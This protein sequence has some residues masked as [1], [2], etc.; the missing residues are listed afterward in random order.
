MSSS[1][2]TNPRIVTK[3]DIEAI[4]LEPTFD[5][6]LI[7]AMADGFRISSLPST[8]G[9]GF[10]SAPIQT[11]GAYP[12]EPFSVIQSMDD[13]AIYSAQTCIK[14]GYM[15]DGKYYVIKVASGGNPFPNSG[16]MQI[17]SQVTGKLVAILMDDGILTELRTAAAG[18]LAAKLFAPKHIRYVGILG[19]GIQARYQLRFLK[20]VLDCRN[21]LVYGR[22]PAHVETFVTECN[23]DGWIVQTVESPDQLLQDCQLIITTTSAREPILGSTY[24]LDDM[25]FKR[26]H[27]PI[28]ITC[29][30]ADAPGK[31][32][33]YP[34]LVKACDLLVADSL[35]QTEQRGEFQHAIQQ[36]LIQIK[37]IMEIGQFIKDPKQP[38]DEKNT[39]ILDHTHKL[40]IFD[41]SGMAVQDYMIAS[42]VLDSLSHN[43]SR[44]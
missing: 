27:E 16:C 12:L 17:Y 41:S 14:S 36:G 19:T 34:N 33:L 24:T 3:S 30:G 23:Q 42:M 29:I 8:V 22:T 35:V 5:E 39:K 31:M 38:D 9:G 20:T 11:L 43:S 6:R 15:V 21:I 18:A 2:T 32:E 13:S 44:E 37:D 4:T 28:H 25:N 26:D 40:S 10:Q 1:A 7:M